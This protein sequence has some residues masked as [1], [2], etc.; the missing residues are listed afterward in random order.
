MQVCILGVCLIARPQLETDKHK[1]HLHLVGIIV[2]LFQAFFSG[3]F[4]TTPHLL[5][6]WTLSA[7]EVHVLTCSL[8]AN[9]GKQHQSCN[10][11]C[12]V[13]AMQALPRCVCAS[14]AHQRRRM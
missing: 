8:N 9:T 10:Q 7:V 6:P 2:G 12:A 4:V 5:N 1:A 13:V 11:C 14:C 3:A